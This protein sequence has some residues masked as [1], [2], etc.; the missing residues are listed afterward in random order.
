MQPEPI[1]PIAGISSHLPKGNPGDLKVE[2]AQLKEI[3]QSDMSQI[4]PEEQ[5]LLSSLPNVKISV[6]AH[7]DPVNILQNDIDELE[8]D[9]GLIVGEEQA[10]EV[11]AHIPTHTMRSLTKDDHVVERMI[12]HIHSKKNFQETIMIPLE[13]LL[14]ELVDGVK[15]RGAEGIEF[16]DPIFHMPENIQLLSEQIVNDI[17]RSQLAVRVPT[18]ILLGGLLIHRSNVLDAAE[19]LLA[20]I[21][22]G[23]L[24][25]YSKEQQRKL[26]EVIH[27]Q[28]L[29]LSEEKRDIAVETASYIPTAA[30][31]ILKTETTLSNVSPIMT[32]LGISVAL[33]WVATSAYS[34]W[35]AVRGAKLHEEFTAKQ[36]EKGHEIPEN[37]VP[38]NQEIERIEPIGQET[39][40]DLLLKKRK[41]AHQA[42]RSKLKEGFFEFLN[43]YKGVVSNFGKDNSN[44]NHLQSELMKRVSPASFSF[45]TAFTQFL[46]DHAHD[47]PEPEDH[48]LKQEWLNKNLE[49]FKHELNA[50]NITISQAAITPE[51]LKNLWNVE[52][53]RFALLDQYAERQQTLTVETKQAVKALALKKLE[54]ERKFFNFKV[55]SAS[56]LFAMSTIAAAGTIALK[57]LACIGIIAATSIAISVPGLGLFIGG[58]I[59]IGVG[60]FFLYKYKPNLFKGLLK[61][62]AVSLAFNKIPLAYYNYQLHKAKS[63]RD[64]K[65]AYV[66]FLSARIKEI[67]QIKIAQDIHSAHLSPEM[68]ALLVSLKS[69]AAKE[70]LSL[71]KRMAELEK[72]RE[73]LA[74]ELIRYERK[75][76]VVD[77]R[78]AEIEKTL[79]MYKKRTDKLKLELADRGTQDFLMATNYVSQKPG[80]GRRVIDV[81]E[82]I[83][84]NIAAGNIDEESK[85]IF[86]T[87]MGINLEDHQSDKEQVKNAM[88]HYFGLDQEDMEKLIRKLKAR[89]DVAAAAA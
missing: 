85:E 41:D 46:A 24:P 30:Q 86:K 79:D 39:P 20:R 67:E 25:N 53:F 87:K 6:V 37:Q 50:G 13:T 62:T 80:Q 69:K 34:L 58:T 42:S 60:L 78:I 51:S 8:E 61:G 4:H 9:A 14:Q 89:E 36:Y 15:E 16:G 55:G 38:V 88:K 45:A 19:H 65:T 54:S 56:T 35:K 18:Q 32:G 40:I 75:K 21:K 81:S 31:L 73:H 83:A 5:P 63:L 49:A 33:T 52:S 82:I 27:A 1:E 66:N 10:A 47:S 17:L 68:T 26:E 22:N 64:E 12:D 29:I 74:E 71:D 44:F 23:E 48:L 11:L 57:V 59:L 84:E 28:K 77:T 76:E 3:D 72:T 2:R 43:A 70:E 7:G